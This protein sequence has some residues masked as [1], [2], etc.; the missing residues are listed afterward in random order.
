VHPLR[1]APP[2]PDS[3]LEY[4]PVDES[5]LNICMEFKTLINE[6]SLAANLL[7]VNKPLLGK[8]IQVLSPPLTTEASSDR[9]E[10]MV[11]DHLHTKGANFHVLPL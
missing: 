7:F 3:A 5:Q 11:M 2:S 1:I 9:E 6:N 4:H 10:N 8:A